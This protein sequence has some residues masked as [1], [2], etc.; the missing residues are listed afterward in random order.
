M[1][2]HAIGWWDIIAETREKKGDGDWC[3]AYPPF[4]TVEL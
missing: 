1:T 3:S 2:R 4:Q